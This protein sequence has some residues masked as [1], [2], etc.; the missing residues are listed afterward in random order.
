VAA[1][2]EA[3]PIALEPLSAEQRRVRE[4]CF[5]EEHR[6]VHEVCR[7]VDAAHVAGRSIEWLAAS[8]LARLPQ[9]SPGFLGVKEED[10][11]GWKEDRRCPFC[12]P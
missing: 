9:E 11:S 3:Q 4:L 5:V 12:P 1:L 6:P 2:L 7:E 10:G 8:N